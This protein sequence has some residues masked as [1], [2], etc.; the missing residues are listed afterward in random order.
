MKPQSPQRQLAV[1]LAKYDPA[2][3][4]LAKKARAKMQKL[5]PGAVEMVYD[6]YNALVIGFGTT[7]RSSEALFSIVL[8]PRYVGLCFLFGAKLHD[9]H[10]LLKGAGKRVRWIRLEDAAVLDKPAVQELIAAALES[11]ATP[12][13][14]TSPNR[15]VIRSISAKQRPR[16]PAR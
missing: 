12:L 15:L 5:L 9:P 4:A 1:F 3:A 10:K 6:N 13:D 8:Y 7:D 2:I 16:R 11:A 14:E